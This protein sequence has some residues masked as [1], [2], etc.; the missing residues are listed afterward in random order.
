MALSLLSTKI[1]IPPANSRRIQRARLF[2]CLNAGLCHK[3]TLLSAPAGF[4]K[5]SLLADWAAQIAHPVAWVSLDESD[6]DPVRFMAYFI[7]ALQKIRP[8]VGEDMLSVLRASQTPPIDALLTDL[9]NEMESI[10]NDFL[11]ILDDFHLIHNPDIHTPLALMVER[12]PRQVHLVIASRADP[13]L[14][15]ARLRARD[16]LTELRAAHLRFTNQEI[17]EFLRTT[18]ALDLNPEEINLLED[19]TEGWIAGLQLAAVSLQGRNAEQTA[20]FIHA[21]TGSHRFILDY[22]LEEVLQNQ[23]DEILQFLLQTSILERLNAALCD[24]LTGRNDSQRILESIERANLF[25]LPL[26][27][28]RQWYRYHALFADSLRQ[29]LHLTQAGSIPTLHRRASQWYEMAAAENGEREFI[30][31]AIHHARQ[32]GDYDRMAIL[33]EK[34]AEPVFM[35]GE[36]TTLITWFK[37]LPAQ[38][39][40]SRPAMCVYRAWIALL[41]SQIDEAEYWLHTAEQLI[42]PTQTSDLLGQI[43][44]AR[45]LL[46]LYRGELVQAAET[47]RHAVTHVSQA[48]NLVANILSWLIGFTHWNTTDMDSAAA[49]RYMRQSIELSRKSGNALI[50]SLAIY[51]FGYYQLLRGRLNASEQI[52]RKELLDNTLAP[53][54]GAKN[55]LTLSYQVL[56]EIA[57]ER[58]DLQTARQY[59]DEALRLVEPWNSAEILIDEYV[60]LAHIHYSLGNPSQALEV[61][62]QTVELARQYQIATVTTRLL[63]AYQAQM[64]IYTGDLISAQEWAEKSLPPQESREI[65]NSILAYL[66]SIEHITLA[67]LRLAQGNPLA[68][69]QILLAQIDRMTKAGWQRI[70][71][72]MQVQLT[73]ALAVQ[74]RS[75]EALTLL[76]DILARAEPEGYMRLFLDEGRSMLNMLTRLDQQTVPT[77]V[78]AYLHRLLKAASETSRPDQARPVCQSHFEH[79]ATGDELLSERE[80]EVLALAAEGLSNQEIAARLVVAVSTVKSHIHSIYRKLQVDSRTA[81]V[82]RARNAGIL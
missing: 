81:A 68:A 28:Q 75:S 62:E 2:A 67:R 33:I 32:G 53:N 19:R 4:G 24:T 79:A 78:H 65:E 54:H 51:S 49:D 71:L 44:A 73:L 52:F 27:D 50:G 46:H 3:L 20:S 1:H 6:N 39:I 10:P 30:A 13:P 63:R 5:T 31:Q 25:I 77:N 9:L 66:C 37:T 80:L 76:Q 38:S 41:M 60:V 59:I 36:I 11:L 58:N 21:F 22:L 69:E 15:L 12:L 56:A 57:R 16:Q 17:G 61:L 18:I 14:P 45:A 82:A 23:P 7:A 35:A 43:D 70:V 48:D 72:D 55:V 29:R 64:Q 47:A 8:G 26:D 40:Q 34:I 74:G 42:A